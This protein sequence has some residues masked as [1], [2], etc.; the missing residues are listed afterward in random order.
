MLC[1]SGRPS[2]STNLPQPSGAGRYGA[3]PTLGSEERHLV[4]GGERCVT[5]AWHRTGSHGVAIR[6]GGGR[7]AMGE[8]G[9]GVRSWQFPKRFTNHTVH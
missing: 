2:P 5:V 7:R 8:L 6:P 1:P 9:F 3:R 4:L